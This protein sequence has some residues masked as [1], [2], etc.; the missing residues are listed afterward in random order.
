MDRQAEGFFNGWTRKEAYLKARGKGLSIPLDQFVV[1]LSPG[2]PARLLKAEGNP[3]EGSHW[4][5][6]DLRPGPGYVAALVVEG[7]DC[8]LRCWQW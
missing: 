1:S 2:E 5:M 4:S 3:R 7:Q 8:R 6:W